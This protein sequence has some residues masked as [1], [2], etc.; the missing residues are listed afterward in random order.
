MT[1]NLSTISLSQINPDLLPP[2]A[3]LRDIVKNPVVNS[4]EPRTDIARKRKNASINPEGLWRRRH[5]TILTTRGVPVDQKIAELIETLWTIGFETL[6]SCEGDTDL[7][8]ENGDLENLT[9][10]AHV[11]FPRVEDAVLF[12]ERSYSFLIEYRPDLPWCY[13]MNLEMMLP[14]ED[15][16]NIRAIVRFN[17]AALESLTAYWKTSL[18]A[19]H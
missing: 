11:I 13:L 1:P 19:A 6:Y 17:P 5:K 18:S 12:M 10:A 14:T 2:K 7:Y 3:P 16:R 4:I 15:I 9:D 8:D